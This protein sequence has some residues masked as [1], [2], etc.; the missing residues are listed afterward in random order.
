M[1]FMTIKQVTDAMNKFDFIMLRDKSGEYHAINTKIL[2]CKKIKADLS[3]LNENKSSS[4]LSFKPCSF[5]E[6]ISKKRPF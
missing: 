1:I 3:K 4:F 2:K 5:N 6:Y